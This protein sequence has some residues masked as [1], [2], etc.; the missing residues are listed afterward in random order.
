[1]QLWMK[2]SPC[3]LDFMFQWEE[4]NNK[5]IYNII[6]SS[7]KHNY[8]KVNKENQGKGLESDEG[9]FSGRVQKWP[10]RVSDIVTE[11][12][13]PAAQCSKANKGARLVERKVCFILD[14]SNWG[15]WRRADSCPKAIS[16]PPRQSVGK[17]FYRWREGAAWR[18]STV[19]SDSHLEIG[20]AVIWWSD[21]RHLDWFFFVGGA[22]REACGILVSWP[23]IEPRPSAVREW[24]PNH[25]TASGWIPPSWWF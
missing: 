15:G 10:L 25:W 20:H 12:G 3:L 4:T 17:S 6:S 21:Q 9:C 2:Q 7:D 8:E 14:A 11:S 23:G 24:S 22:C 5:Q 18:N 19:S 1:M 13:G 16:P